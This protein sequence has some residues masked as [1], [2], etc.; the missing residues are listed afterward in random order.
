MYSY[1]TVCATAKI[2]GRYLLSAYFSIFAAYLGVG[3]CMGRTRQST[4][5]AA[6]PPYKSTSPHVQYK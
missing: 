1:S 2:S 6:I 5:Y 3:Y 4:E